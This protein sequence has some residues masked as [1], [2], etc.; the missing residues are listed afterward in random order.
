MRGG[1][2]GAGRV[3]VEGQIMPARAP[4]WNGDRI[5]PIFR[6]KQLRDGGHEY[7]ERDGASIQHEKFEAR[8][9]N[10]VSAAGG[11]G[12]LTERVRFKVRALSLGGAKPVAIREA[13]GTKW[14]VEAVS[15]PM[16]DQHGNRGARDV[17]FIECFRVG[18]KS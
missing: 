17:V 3:Y 6:T 14:D 15:T 13:D 10:T 8:G 5:T 12:V 1:I 16:P 2:D 11:D 7:I 18:G 4:I 9:G